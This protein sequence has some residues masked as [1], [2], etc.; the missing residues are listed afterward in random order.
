LACKDNFETGVQ[1]NRDVHTSK[2]SLKEKMKTVSSLEFEVSS[3]RT[4]AST[5]KQ[6]LDVQLKKKMD[7][8]HFQLKN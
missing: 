1:L 6:S 8:N 4:I 5:L 7:R 3:Q 2:K